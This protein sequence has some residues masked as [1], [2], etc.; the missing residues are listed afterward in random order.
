MAPKLRS[1]RGLGR[2]AALASAITLCAAGCGGQRAPDLVLTNARVVTLDSGDHTWTTIAIGG[3]KIV[4]LTN[5]VDPH[6]LAFKPTVIDVGG[7]VVAP[8][9]TDHHVHL[10]NVGMALLN[11][12]DGGR[13]AID[14]SGVRSLAAVDSLVRA[15]AATLPAGTWILGAGWSQANWGTHT[16]PTADV[17]TRAAPHHPVFLARTDGHAGWLNAAALAAAGITGATPSP[18]GGMIGHLSSGEPSGILLERANELMT[19][20]LPALADSDVVTAYRLAADALARRGVVEVYDA[21]PLMYPGVT[22]LNMDIARYVTLLIRAD[23]IA[24]LPLRVNLMIP[25]PSRFADSL[26]GAA[27]VAT[28]LSPRIH[29]THVKLF[30]DGALGSRGAALTHRYADDTTTSGVPRM[31]SAQIVT[32]GE[33]ALDHG[34]GVATHA[35]GDEAVHRTLDAYETIL[36]DRTSAVRG[37]LRIEHFSYASAD[38]MARAARLGIILSVQ[39]TFNALPDDTLPL[40]TARLGAANEARVYN[41][42]R[43]SALH[44]ILAEGSDYFATP[45]PA[46]AGFAA[47]LGRRYALGPGLADSGARRVAYH[48]NAAR[49]DAGGTRTGG[50]LSVGEAADLVVWSA[51]PFSVAR[52]DLGGVTALAVVNAGRVV[53]PFAARR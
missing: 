15:R 48:M 42:S 26:L 44:A 22:A 17:L 29:I 11:A 13:L 8:A 36:H 45:G 27:K 52:G 20:R 33:R 19:A 31:T 47:M 5:G 28:E 37:R 6:W 38:D 9:F 24:P 51:D 30:S 50:W 40:G 7:A 34:L 35:I 41:W 16:L 49:F 1:G 39:S 4:A 2:L 46:L 53:V 23:S 10:F 43:L 21:G 25:A 32:I 3:G 14:L 12:R 18:E